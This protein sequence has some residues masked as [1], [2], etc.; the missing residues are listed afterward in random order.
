MKE[1]L[2]E[3]EVKR[4]GIQRMGF[5]LHRNG[6]MVSAPIRIRQVSVRLN[7]AK[8]VPL[9]PEADIVNPASFY[10]FTYATQVAIDSCA[11]AIWRWCPGIDSWYAS[12]SA[13]YRGR[14]S[15]SVVLM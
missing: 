5:T 10:E 9:P 3:P 13:S 11:I 6:S 14:V 12:A 1:A 4:R 15:G 8:I 2:D 7:S